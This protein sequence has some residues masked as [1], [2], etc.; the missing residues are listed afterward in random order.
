MRTSVRRWWLARSLRLRMTAYAVVF[1]GTVV[2]ALPLL[3]DLAWR[4]WVGPSPEL[5]PWRRAGWVLAAAS[6]AAYGCCSARLVRDGGGAYVEFDPPTRLVTAGPYRR[7]RNPVA[8]CVVGALAGLALA[9]SSAGA[10]VLAAAAAGAAHAQV[11]WIEEPRLARRFGEA[12]GR[13]AAEVPRW[14]PFGRR[15]RGG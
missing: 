7:C 11:R 3:A 13:Y 4:S 14:S 1:L 15:R 5:G 2:G 8:L 12:Y 10:A 9:R 6:L